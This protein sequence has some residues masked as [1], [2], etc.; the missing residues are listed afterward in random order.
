MPTTH[1]A[2]PGAGAGDTAHHQPADTVTGVRTLLA[3]DGN[4][5]THRSYHALA[6]TNLHDAA[7]RPT[8]AVKGFVNQLLSVVERVNPDA[9]VIG[10]DDAGNSR[11]KG[12]L[13]DYKGTRSEKPQELKSQLQL[14]PQVL[15]DAGISVVIPTGLEADDVTAAASKFAGE[16]GWRCVIATSDRDAFA[17]ISHHTHVL[18]IL[19]GGIENSPILTPERLPALNG[20]QAGQYLDYAAMRGDASDNL[21]G[22]RGIGE[23]T[24]QKLLAAFGSA[25]AMW[26]A[27]DADEDGTAVATAAGKATVTKLRAD[28]AREAWQL[29]R[30]MMSAH[31]DVVVGHEHITPLPLDPAKLTSALESVSLV[32]TIR[33]ATNTLC[34]TQAPAPTQRRRP[35]DPEPTAPVAPEPHLWEAA[36]PPSYLDDY[37]SEPAYTAGPHPAAALVGF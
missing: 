28:G 23:K 8:W 26:A 31:P 9:I 19:N 35:L 17:H 10:F 34:G 2:H 22:I 16:N 5:L 20:L 4:S 1:Q 24:A 15:A 37:D 18:R 11:R 7:G 12:Y 27:L 36:E 3:I 33:S 14:L 13:P 30:T 29:N 32:A 6:G 21:P 25:E